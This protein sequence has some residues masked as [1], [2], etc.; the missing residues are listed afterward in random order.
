[1]TATNSCRPGNLRKTSLLRD[2]SNGDAVRRQPTNL[3]KQR[4]RP[5][6]FP[7]RGIETARSRA[8]TGRMCTVPDFHPG[9]A[10]SDLLFTM[11]DNTHRSE[12]VGEPTGKRFGANRCTFW[13]SRI[14]ADAAMRK[15]AARISRIRH[16]PDTRERDIAS[17]PTRSNG[18]RSGGARRDRTDDLLLAKQALS[19]L[20]YGPVR[21]P[22]IGQSIIRIH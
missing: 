18:R 10:W 19:Q 22:R 6:S 17:G 12:T 11:S 2:R 21:R 14:A 13:T 5:S 20:S 8:R 9:R 15:Q 16:K 3:H 1:M 4:D 7:S